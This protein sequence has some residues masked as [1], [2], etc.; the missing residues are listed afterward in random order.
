M[1][2]DLPEYETF[3][4]LADSVRTGS[5]MV[6]VPLCR[7]LMSDALTPGSGLSAVGSWG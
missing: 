3:K 7:R 2:Y 6:V 1:A 5:G 4:R